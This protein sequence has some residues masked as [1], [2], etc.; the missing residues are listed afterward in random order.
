MRFV[1]VFAL[2]VSLAVSIMLVHN[3]TK[4]RDRN[5][6]NTLIEIFFT[7]NIFASLASVF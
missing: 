4:D 1:C 2:A 7:V 3:S 5:V 6:A